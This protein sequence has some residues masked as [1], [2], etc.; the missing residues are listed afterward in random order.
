MSV[1]AH[2][3]GHFDG[4]SRFGGSLMR[5]NRELWLILSL[6][7]VAGLLNWLV[8]SDRM[9]L[10]FYTLPTLFSAY[11]F[12]RRHAVL[13]AI[14]SILLV[15]II[16]FYNPTL[17]RPATASAE[18]IARWFDVSLW[19]GLLIITAYTMGT[20]YER[21]EA[22]LREVRKAYFGVLTI[23]QQ[24]IS[25]D[26]YAHNHS[27]R[28]ALYSCAIANRM[29][30]ETERIDDIRAAALLHEIGRLD[31]S[32]ELLFKVVSLTP[33]EMS[34]V[35]NPAQKGIAIRET[36]GGSLGRIVPIIL[37]HHE[38]QDGSGAPGTKTEESPLEARVLAVADAYDT[39]TSDRPYRRAV[40]PFEAKEL[41][42]RGAGTNFDPAVIE[43]FV[44]AFTARDL[45]LPEG[46]IL[47]G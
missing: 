2:S 5:V 44:A 12:G 45:D 18:P 19:G 40:S 35:R 33:E 34:E 39:L 36:I 37:A 29:G 26:K 6:F 15:F 41:I 25:N 14:A 11:V 16:S 20:L 43:A 28:V 17:F 10:G 21:K 30:L 3:I 4:R 47:Q 8:V 38:R 46:L 27:Y 13:T 1:A 42:Q 9:I 24:V 22:Y 32:R 7:V 23:L 31:T